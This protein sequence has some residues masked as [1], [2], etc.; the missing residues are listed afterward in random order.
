MWS[1]ELHFSSYFEKM[2][3]LLA[4][5]Q[6]P[7][8]T[9]FTV[10]RRRV[11]RHLKHICS[12][13]KPADSSR[14]IP[15]RATQATPRH[16]LSGDENNLSLLIPT[17]YWSL[18]FYFPFKKYYK[19]KKIKVN[20]CLIVTWFIFSVSVWFMSVY[21]FYANQWHLQVLV[22]VEHTDCLSLE[23]YLSLRCF[24]MFWLWDCDC[25]EP[26]RG[27]IISEVNVQL[28]HHPK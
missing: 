15:L 9:N 13:N 1:A 14:I 19:I 17:N 21:M 8:Y 5:C 26:S 11:Q 20:L 10:E 22:H 2:F 6:L 28:N 24:V 25:N 4:G 12:L 23:G 7:N 16:F 18:F 3:P 27:S